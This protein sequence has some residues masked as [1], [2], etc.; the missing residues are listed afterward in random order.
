MNARTRVLLLTACMGCNQTALSLNMTV[1]ALAGTMLAG[2]SPYLATLPLAC[3]F[4]TIMLSSGPV[5]LLMGRF[6]RKPCF[7]L[8][9]IV[10]AAGGLISAWAILEGSLWLFA[11]GMAVYGYATATANYYR[12]AAAEAVPADQ[13]S[14]AISTVLTG[15]VVAA[16]AGPFLAV[17]GTDLFVYSFAGSFMIMAALSIAILPLL[18]FVHFPAIE[19]REEPDPKR[20]ARPL[21]QIARQKVFLLAAMGGMV[22]YG[23]MNLIMVSTPT[24]MIAC[25]FVMVDAASVIQWHVLGMYLPSF[26]TGHLIRRYGAPQIMAIGAVLMM[27][28]AVINLTGITYLHFAASLVLLG[29]GWN[30]LYVGGSTLVTE[31]YRPGERSRTLG[32]NEVLVTGTTAATALGSGALFALAGWEVLNLVVLPA[33]IL[34]LISLAWFALSRRGVLPA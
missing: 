11:L 14:R 16:I 9:A 31:A 29:V 10:G 19:A 28:C 20:P 12:F 26:F 25:G 2:A 34:V 13:R 8:G 32:L 33:L 30:F 24:A 21:G 18:A 22:G 7:A 6:G 5:S 1:A 4:V 3:T 15:G 23:A 27:I 17:Q